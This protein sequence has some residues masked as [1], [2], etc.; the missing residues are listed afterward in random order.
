MTKRPQP[1]SGQRR[2]SRRGP[3]EAGQSALSHGHMS[4]PFTSVHWSLSEYVYAMIVCHLMCGGVNSGEKA[5]LR[6]EA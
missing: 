4:S 1:K 2:S 5:A 3:A 6:V